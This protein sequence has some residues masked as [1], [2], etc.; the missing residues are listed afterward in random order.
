ML[1]TS[2][3]NCNGDLCFITVLPLEGKSREESIASAYEEL[4]EY[5]RSHQAELLQERIYG[6]LSAAPDA[7]R[8]RQS[9]LTSNGKME[10]VP[11]TYVEGTPFYGLDFAGIHAIAAQSSDPE[12][13]DL[14]RKNDRICGCHYCGNEAEYLILS[15]ISSLLQPSIR[16]TR[17]QETFEAINLAGE[18]LQERSWSY[19]DVRRTWF[20]LDDILAWYPDFNK[21]R[22][23]LYKRLGLFNG[24]PKTIIPASTGIWGRSAY[25][26]SCTFDLLAMKPIE[27]CPLETRRLENP[28]QN[29]AT[30]YGSAFSRGVAIATNQ[31]KYIF[32]SGT[33]SIDESGRTVYVGDMK[34]QTERT[35]LNIESLLQ[36]AGAELHHIQRATA[37]I[38]MEE[39]IPVFED[40]LNQLGMS[41]IPIV[42]TIADVCRDDLLFELDA[43]AVI[44]LR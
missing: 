25:G 30:D 33:A 20:Y 40:I 42:R 37:F 38:K 28:K 34:R 35:L 22:N 21:A 16:S 1:Y 7:E 10:R 6:L 8:I 11:S 41:D 5:L 19:R 32:V 3:K 36:G 27:G 17:A 12:K 2:T 15:D 23:E 44:P 14:V 9:I 4:A 26:A 29:E 18:I 43:T 13:I 31:S 39:D 24:N